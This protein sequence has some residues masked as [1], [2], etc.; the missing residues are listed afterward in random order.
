M[1]HCTL[2]PGGPQVY[3]LWAR[4]HPP[5]VL[6][7][8]DRRHEGLRRRP[9]GRGH[10]QRPPADG[11]RIAGVEGI[12]PPSR[13]TGKLTT[14]TAAIAAARTRQRRDLHPAR[15]GRH[16]RAGRL[17][18]RRDQPRGLADDHHVRRASPTLAVIDAVT[19]AA[20][21]PHA[22]STPVRAQHAAPAVAVL[23]RRRAR[24]YA[25]STSTSPRGAGSAPGATTSPA[26]TPT[27]TPTSTTTTRREPV[28]GGARR[29]S[30]TRG[31]TGSSRSTSSNVDV[32]RQPLPLLVE[33]EQAVLLA[34]Q[35][36][37][38]RH[39][40]LL[41]RQQL[42]RP[43]AAGA[44]RLHRGGRQLPA[45][46]PQPGRAR[47]ATPSTPRPTTAP[48]PTTA[49]PTAPTSTTP[50]WP[51]RRTAS[52]AMQMYLQ[53]QPGTSYPDGDPFVADQRRRRG[54][55]RLPRVHAR[56][57]QPAG[58]RRPRATRTLGGVQA[59]AMGEAWS[60]WYAMDYLVDAGPAEGPTRAR[61]TCVLFQYDGAGVA[62]DRT[63]PID[64]TVGVRRPRCCNGGA[65]GH[66]GGY[67][68][69]RL[70]PGGRRPRGA[71]RRRDLGAD[72]VGPAR[73][74]SARGPPSRW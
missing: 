4:G 72:A 10:P 41:L 9:P 45:G 47:A 44:D 53:H 56:P 25:E 1:E 37:A 32:L 3:S 16:R 67:T 55:H 71:H 5:P 34:G 24:R 6:D 51:R 49:C 8:G 64:C 60:D 57:V 74:G 33:P 43:P 39:A 50:T 66:R 63:E 11:L 31:T 14:P 46:Q 61:S 21:L 12:A 65:T 13:T 26:T 18:H 22:R 2:A 62:L 7:A 15:P 69:A 40:G 48:T 35:P 58:R 17:R 23:P 29:R 27:P 68:Y 70:R 52:A 42:A 30:G 28:R 36:R 59:G 54:R 19:G 20:P 38:E 73:R